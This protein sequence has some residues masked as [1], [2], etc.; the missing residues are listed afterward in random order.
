M[1]FVPLHLLPPNLVVEV[2]ASKAGEFVALYSYLP[3]SVVE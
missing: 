2:A 1:A 3:L